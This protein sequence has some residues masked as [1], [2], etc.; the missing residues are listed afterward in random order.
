MRRF[1]LKHDSIASLQA[2]LLRLVRGREGL[3]RVELA[4][5]LNLAPSTVGIH[6]DH[7]TQEGFLSESKRVRRDF[8]RPPTALRL[9][10]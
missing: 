5:R 7:L 9:N 4:R 3:S 2:D 1:K 6:V 8:G 10:A